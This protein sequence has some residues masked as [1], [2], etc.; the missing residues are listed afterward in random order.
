MKL[1]T[2]QQLAQVMR[3]KKSVLLFAG[4]YCDEMELGGSLLSDYAS[5]ISLRLDAPIAASANTVNRLRQKKAKVAK[6][7]AIE[8]VEML[9]YPDW[10]DP[11]TAPRPDLCVFI[12]FSNV[13]AAALAHASRGT[14]TVVLGMSPS[15]DATYGFAESSQSG[16]QSNLDALL[17]A[18]A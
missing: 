18:L 10:R 6:K 5:N 3:Q 11:I 9:R 12:G 13:V 4:P 16:L 17:A 7:S 2:P 15:P 1:S 14:D 8:L